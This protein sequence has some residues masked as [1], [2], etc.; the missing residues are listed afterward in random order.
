MSSGKNL[1]TSKKR[2]KAVLPAEAG[3]KG[4][5]KGKKKKSVEVEYDPDRDLMLVRKKHKRGGDWGD[6]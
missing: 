1:M 5:K 4:K 6:W 2:K 3:K